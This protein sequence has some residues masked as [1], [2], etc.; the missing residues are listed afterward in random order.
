MTIASSTMEPANAAPG[1]L[2]A[3]ER[4]VDIDRAVEDAVSKLSGRFGGFHAPDIREGCLRVSRAIAAAEPS[5]VEHGPLLK[6]FAS[7][8]AAEL[9]A[10]AIRALI[11]CFVDQSD[12]PRNYRRFAAECATAEGR[13][14]IL[15][16]YPELAR[17]LGLMVDHVTA[18]FVRVLS[19]ALKDTPLLKRT[20]DV[21]GPITE[22]RTG[23]GD[24]HHGGSTV[25][26]VTWR[27]GAAVH[28]PRGAQQSRFVEQLKACLDPTG[29][30]F[31]PLLPRTID[32]GESHC[33]QNLVL[34]EDLPDKHAAAEYYRRF[35]AATALATALGATDLHYENV[36]ATA[37]GPVILDVETMASLSRTASKNGSAAEQLSHNLDRGPLHTMLLPMRFLGAAIDIDISGLG[38]THA[39]EHSR[40]TTVRVTAEGTDDIGFATIP[41]TVG[42]G[43]NAATLNTVIIDPR[44]YAIELAQGYEAGRARLKQKRADVERLILQNA[45][46]RTRAVIRPTYIYSRFLDAS[47]HPVYLKD[48]EDRRRLFGKLPA[49]RLLRG[50]PAAAVRAVCAEEVEALLDLDVPYFEIDADSPGLVSTGAHRS[51]TIAGATDTAARAEMLSSLESFLTRPPQLDQRDLRLSLI[52]STDDVWSRPLGQKQRRPIDSSIL[53]PEEA[54]A[55]SADGKSL[56]WLSVMTLGEGLRLAPVSLGFYEG[57]GELLAAARLGTESVRATVA[58]AV[59]G[60]HFHE[61]PPTP[62]PLHL[63][64]FVGSLADHITCHELSI[65]EAAPWTPAPLP[66]QYASLIGEADPEDLDYVGGLG[67]YYVS[68]SRYQHTGLDAAGLRRAAHAYLDRHG[69]SLSDWS[70]PGL[71]HG[72]SGR[73]AAFNA[74]STLL[75]GD[76]RIDEALLTAIQTFDPSTDDLRDTASNGTWCRGYAGIL[77]VLVDVGHRVGEPVAGAD[78]FGA[79]LD[80]LARPEEAPEHD[81][82]LCH[83]VAGR[84]MALLDLANLLDRPELAARA[85]GVRDATQAKVDNGAWRSGLGRAPELTSFMLGT[86]GWLLASAAVDAPVAFPSL[87]VAGR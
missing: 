74:V 17:L 16:A 60:S 70:K 2:L 67:A 47:T 19:D 69:P 59:R 3:D 50:A 11:T 15:D 84:M 83:G 27:S 36:I 61:V 38:T 20:L 37:G 41:A 71:A 43:P 72:T 80:L 78:W 8:L 28:K 5:A 10:V 1:D 48:R 14:V 34:N 25:A 64:P 45:P 23:Q 26:F 77:P 87:L 18:H 49:P 51:L 85:S 7:C 81:V 40:L 75:G 55:S 73:I 24:R 86:S 6:S 12:G 4:D 63:S 76:R 35:G 22:I 21:S 57:G 68:L 79:A 54:M 30:L 66:G 56:T 33:W 46:P 82:S 39:N 52:S 32:A 65:D 29:A 13:S 9:D 62:S 42:R 31:G 58:A 53:P 44:E